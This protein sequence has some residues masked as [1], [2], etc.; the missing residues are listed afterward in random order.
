MILRENECPLGLPKIPYC[1]AVVG[2][3]ARNMTIGDYKRNRA[4][5][6]KCR[7]Q[8]I[9]ARCPYAEKL[10]IKKKAVNCDIEDSAP[11]ISAFEP[12]GGSPIYPRLW[13][14][15]NTINLDRQYHSYRGPF[16]WFSIQGKNKANKRLSSR[17]VQ[18]ES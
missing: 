11:G 2:E 18:D 4:I 1:C 3:T 16:G 7:N 15:F 12:S 14:G 17:E 9:K 8:G 5:F 6:K 13:E 10:F